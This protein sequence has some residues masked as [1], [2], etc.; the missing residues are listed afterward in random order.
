MYSWIWR[1]L[2]G[3]I[4]VRVAS[5]VILLLGVLAL[6]FLVVFPAV[7]PHILFDDTPTTGRG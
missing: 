1:H 6:L 7:G 3:P 2:P 4:G 5:A